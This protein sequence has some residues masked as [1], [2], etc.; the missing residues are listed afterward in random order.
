MLVGYKYV[1]RKVLFIKIL[2]VVICLGVF[3]VLVI[4]MVSLKGF[5]NSFVLNLLFFRKIFFCYLFC[6]NVFKINVFWGLGLK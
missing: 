1:V 4:F 3:F 5:L 6:K 2:N